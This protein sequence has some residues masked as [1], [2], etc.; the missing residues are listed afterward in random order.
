MLDK[1]KK[2]NFSIKTVYAKEMEIRKELEK[3][4]RQAIEDVRDE[5]NRK[6]NENQ[7]IYKPQR[8]FN[9]HN[10]LSSALNEGAI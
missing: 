4:L 2:D 3:I 9:Q 8:K 1:E 5:I 6:R 7:N 10:A